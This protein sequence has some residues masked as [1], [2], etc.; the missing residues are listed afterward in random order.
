MGAEADAGPVCGLPGIREWIAF[1]HERRDE[2]VH[3]VRM[4]PA[5]ARALGK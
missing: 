4:A 2:L 1:F 3:E 5:V